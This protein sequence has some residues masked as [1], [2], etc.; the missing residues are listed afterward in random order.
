MAFTQRKIPPIVLPLNPRAVIVLLGAVCL[1]LLAACSGEDEEK[2]RF[3]RIRRATLESETL[4]EW[5]QKQFAQLEALGYVQ[6]SREAQAQR[7]ITLYDPTATIDGYNLYT[8]GHEPS[9]MLMSMTGEILHRWHYPFEK[10]WARYPKRGDPVHSKF[11]RRVH[12]YRNGDLLAVFEGL[13]MIK[14]DKDSKLLWKS[15][16]R[17]HHDIDVV[18][19]RIYSLTRRRTVIKKV[20]P[21]KPV[22]E[23]FIT[24]MEPDGTVIRE[25]S[26]VWAMRRFREHARYWDRS[27]LNR[28]DIFHTNS[29]EVLDGRAADRLDE[30]A[31]GNVLVSMSNL[32]AIFVVNL[33]RKAIVWGFSDDFNAQHDARILENGHLLLF[34]NLRYHRRSRESRVIEYVLPTMGKAWEYNST[35]AHRFYTRT[36]GTAQRLANGDT[37][38]TETD[39]GRAFEVTR[40]G[41]KVWEFISPHRAGEEN[42][43]VAS[44][45][46]VERIPESYVPWLASP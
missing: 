24:V 5:Q 11:W 39:N 45:F 42:R 33:K 38:I 25:V 7:G 18:G 30:F 10:A 29:L 4:P 16:L 15:D 9:A 17:Q 6:G 3:R 2:G 44:L 36:C 12:L 35:E 27:A 19:D 31:R 13:G 43:L 14:I 40:D 37:L 32:N 8:S 23:D 22:I 46:E 21:K 28:G 41:R 34:D 1:G 26:M 20:N